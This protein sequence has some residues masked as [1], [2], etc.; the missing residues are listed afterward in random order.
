M[1][2]LCQLKPINQNHFH[3]DSLEKMLSRTGH[4]KQLGLT[5]SNDLIVIRE[6]ILHYVLYVAKLSKMGRLAFRQ[7]HN[8]VFYSMNL[9]IVYVGIFS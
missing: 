8:N 3:K 9:V 7:M 1:L 5:A 2:T 6:M 4:S